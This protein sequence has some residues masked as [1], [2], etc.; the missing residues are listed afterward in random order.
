M[1]KIIIYILLTI[2][3]LGLDLQLITKIPSS[4]LL[5]PEIFNGNENTDYFSISDIRK[6]GFFLVGS[7]DQ[8]KQ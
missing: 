7:Y 8:K 4:E 3:A 1:N 6:D 2:N 5:R